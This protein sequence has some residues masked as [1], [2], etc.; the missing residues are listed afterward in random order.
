[1]RKALTAVADRLYIRLGFHN[2]TR[3]TV[4]TAYVCGVVDTLITLAIV[5]AVWGVAK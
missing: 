1:M 5:F 2:V 4:L 3:Q